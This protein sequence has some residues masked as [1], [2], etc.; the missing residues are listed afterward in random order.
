VAQITIY[1]P[2]EIAKALRREARLA[3]KSLSQHLTELATGPR[4]KAASWPKGFFELQG[5]CQ[6]SLEIPDDPPPEEP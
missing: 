6:G 5:S 4:N 3:K 1:V 2:D